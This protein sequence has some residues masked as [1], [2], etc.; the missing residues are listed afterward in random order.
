LQWEDGG[1]SADG[2]AQLFSRCVEHLLAASR[3][4]DL[5]AVARE[6]AR[7]LKADTTAASGD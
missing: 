4:G 7:D 3:D 5:G 1:V 6:L 2:R